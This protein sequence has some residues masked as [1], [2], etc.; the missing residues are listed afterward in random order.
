MKHYLTY[1]A[2]VVMLCLHTAAADPSITYDADA[3]TIR[4]EG[5]PLDQPATPA[6]ILNADR[7]NGWNAVKYD[8]ETDTYTVR[9]D[10]AIGR[11]DDSVTW[12]RIGSADHPTET[13]AIKGNLVVQEKK[14]TGWRTYPAENGLRIGDADLDSV[15]PTVRFLCDTPQEYGMII[16]NGAAFM[17]YHATIGG[18]SPDPEHRAFWQGTGERFELVGCTLSGIHDLYRM[19]LIHPYHLALRDCVF[20]H[21]HSGFS[22]QPYVTDCTF[23]HMDLPLYDRYHLEA[24][25][26]RCRFENNKHNWKLPYTRKGI[27]AIDCFFGEPQDPTVVCQSFKLPTEA[28][29]RYPSFTAERHLVFETVDPDGK[30]VPGARVTLRCEQD[31]PDTVIQGRARTDAEG[32]TPEPGD[33]QGL[34]V[35]DTVIQAT[36]QPDRPKHTR[37]TYSVRIE[38]DGFEPLEI[39]GVDPDQSWLV[40]RATLKRSRPPA[41]RGI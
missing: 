9:A 38:T 36:D 2:C 12:F 15:K 3:R 13:L 26:E 25:L 19:R 14:P 33:R 23:R 37:Y 28:D 39:P 5:Y 6:D 10:L 20:E 24:T 4:V 40:K 31:D 35:T 22:G 17:A 30:P 18:L 21:M 1:A 7:A 34:R 32:R 8:P 29:R 11:D 16:G 27:R 41:A